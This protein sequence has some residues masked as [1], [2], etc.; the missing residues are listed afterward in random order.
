MNLSERHARAAHA[1]DRAQ[2]LL[3]LENL[4]PVIESRT[5]EAL[6]LGDFDLALQRAQNLVDLDPYD[7]RAWLELG[8]VRLRRNEYELAAEAYVVAAT[9]G[10]PATAIGN[11]M[12]GVCFRQLGQPL[13][14]AFFFK[15]SVQ[16]DAQAI[17]P[18]DEIQRLPDFP[19]L[20]PLKDWSLRS[21][22]A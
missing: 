9:L 22:E 16:S 4:Y 1:T 17:S 10:H 12:A 19:V 14:S 8:Q 7:P 2:T 6:W 15:A 20:S 3:Q 18:R 13:L 5:K 11:H 21:F